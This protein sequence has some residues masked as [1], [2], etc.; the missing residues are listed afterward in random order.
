MKKKQKKYQMYPTKTIPME[1][2]DKVAPMPMC[3]ESVGFI[4]FNEWLKKKKK[5]ADNP[6]KKK[7][8]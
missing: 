1:F 4:G 2:H 8:H 7:K 3:G 6:I 5:S